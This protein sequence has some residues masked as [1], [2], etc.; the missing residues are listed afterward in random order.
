[1]WVGD[2]VNVVVMMA[3]DV[4]VCTFMYVLF[5]LHSVPSGLWDAFAEQTDRMEGIERC[6]VQP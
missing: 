3:G 2:D 5:E 6:R 1:V 4:Y